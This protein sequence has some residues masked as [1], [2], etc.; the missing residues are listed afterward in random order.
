MK[1]AKR[2]F[3]KALSLK[4]ESPVARYNLAMT[5]LALNQRDCAREQ[6]SILKTIEPGLS[7]QLFDQIYQG[8]VIR[9][10]K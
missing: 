9:L 10:M 8:K 2:V 6:Y 1:E 3:E 5:C 4:P 7:V